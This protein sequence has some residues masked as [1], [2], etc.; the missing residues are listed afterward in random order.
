MEMQ[1]K[2]FLDGICG[3]VDKVIMNGC[4][5]C[6]GDDMAVPSNIPHVWYCSDYKLTLFPYE[7][8]S[9][10]IMHKVYL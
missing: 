2:I 4:R 10:K 9:I 5:S 3:Y 7:K 1:N 8:R 6:P